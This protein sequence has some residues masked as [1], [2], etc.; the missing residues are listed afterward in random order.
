MMENKNSNNLIFKAEGFL[1]LI[2]IVTFIF[3]FGFG[4]ISTFRD[5]YFIKNTNL[6]REEITITDIYKSRKSS[7]QVNGF[8]KN[9]T[10]NL[11]SPLVSYGTE[12]KLFDEILDKN[13]GDKL[14]IWY[15]TKTKKSFGRFHKKQ[16]YF[17]NFYIENVVIKNLVIFNIVFFIPLIL[18]YLVIQLRKFLNEKSNKV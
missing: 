11:I 4:N 3:S 17:Y 18:L 12:N 14:P 9:D 16:S 6:I 13:I 10:I 15:D 7:L 1:R 8:I 2:T 5:W